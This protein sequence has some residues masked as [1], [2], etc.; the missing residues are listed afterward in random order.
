MRVDKECSDDS[1]NDKFFAS[2]ICHY[3]QYDI[4]IAI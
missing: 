4:I 3:L 1:K 2:G